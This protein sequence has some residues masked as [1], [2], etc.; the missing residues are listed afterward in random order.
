MSILGNYHKYLSYIED[1][2]CFNLELFLTNINPKYSKF[3]SEIIQSQNFQSFIQNNP[4]QNELFNK[5][6]LKYS[7]QRKTNVNKK[8][9]GI[10]GLFSKSKVLDISVKDIL[11]NTT[12]STDVNS[13]SGNNSAY[14]DNFSKN[15]ED[16]SLEYINEYIVP[17]FFI[18]YPL[19]ESDKIE[20]Y[21]IKFNKSK[22]FI[23][24][25]N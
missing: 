17:P 1:L 18:N 3:Y 22:V 16:K 11:H 24:L 8:P 15:I 19:V 7:G 10:I 13:K 25:N 4:Q 6:I 21:V 5:L 9:S 20:E 12:N 23:Y 2:P 14:S